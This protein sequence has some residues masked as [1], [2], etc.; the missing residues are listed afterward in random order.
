MELSL[1]IA[2]SHPGQQGLE[3]RAREL[4]LE[5]TRDAFVV[6]LKLQKPLLDRF[7]AREVVGGERFALH[8]REVDLDLIEPAGVHRPVDGKH[9]G[10]S[11]PQPL[12]A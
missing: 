9:P 1:S 4:P 3:M 5:R 11:A 7:E 12:D 2:R 8:D 6:A 10:M